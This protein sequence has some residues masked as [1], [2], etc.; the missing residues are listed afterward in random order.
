MRNVLLTVSVVLAAVFALQNVHSVELSFIVWQIQTSVA[1]ALLG[2]LLL[3]AV[4]GV[5]SMLPTTLRARRAAHQA[6]HAAHDPRPAQL[7]PV[8]PTHPADG[9]RPP[10]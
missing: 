4:I 6:R 5:L 8:A 10:G 1:M 2:A 3:G 7:P 9:H